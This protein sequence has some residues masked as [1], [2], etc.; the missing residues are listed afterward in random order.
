VVAPPCGR[1]EGISWVPIDV[2]A[3]VQ[4]SALPEP[5]PGDLVFG[6]T[7]DVN[8]IERLLLRPWV[9]T[10]YQTFGAGVELP[11]TR[12]LDDRSMLRT[13]CRCRRPL[14]DSARSSRDLENPRRH[15]GGLPHH[16]QGRGAEPGPRRST[17]YGT[18]DE[19]RAAAANQ[20]KAGC[21]DRETLH[22]HQVQH[23]SGCRRRSRRVL[24]SIRSAGWRFSLECATCGPSVT[25]TD[26]APD[27][28]R[29]CVESC[30]SPGV[31]VR[32]RVDPP[33]RPAG[34]SG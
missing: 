28:S 8:R 32:R 16:Y 30:Q 9:G 10:C 14:L 27:R 22:R 4:F 29:H 33:A 31:D 2:R 13:N 12:V 6:F 15:L 7:R 11:A 26:C 18:F 1:R 3:S 5:H 24:L 20:P 23:E 34:N 21:H 19:L 25:R 17:W